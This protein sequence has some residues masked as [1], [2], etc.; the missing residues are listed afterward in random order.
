MT[1]IHYLRSLVNCIWR[2]L[3][4]ATLMNSPDKE[5]FL[6]L[7]RIAHNNAV[8]LLAEAEILFAN[9]KY[10]RAYFLAFTGL[11]E[12]AKSQLAA[13]V[14]TGFIKEETFWK[15]FKDHKRKI[16]RMAWASTD[17]ERYLDLELET[18]LE[19]EKPT[20]SGRMNAL[21]VRFEGNKVKRP[22]D[23]LTEDDAR[24]IIKTLR[25]AIDR[26]IEASEVWGEQIGTKGFMK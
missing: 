11:E 6:E 12:I 9:K 2:V 16:K 18:F 10:A 7:Y 21:Y 17:A 4:G 20:I 25:V 23:H 24:A 26:I 1:V 19:I 5:K 22:A 15:Y 14:F 13:D 8:D 3:S